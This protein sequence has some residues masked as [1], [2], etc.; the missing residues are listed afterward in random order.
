MDYIS[1]RRRLPE[2]E[3]KRYIRQIVSAVDYLHRLGILHRYSKHPAIYSGGSRGS[4]GGLLEPP[5][6]P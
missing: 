1:Q 4:S 3:V 2:Q 5:P 6:H